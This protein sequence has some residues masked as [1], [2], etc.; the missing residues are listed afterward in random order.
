MVGVG[1]DGSPR[2]CPLFRFLCHLGHP[3]SLTRWWQGIAHGRKQVLND[4]F[5]CRTEG[6]RVPLGQRDSLSFCH[7]SLCECQASGP[8]WEQDVPLIPQ[9][10]PEWPGGQWGATPCCFRTASPP[11]RLPVSQK[12]M[13]TRGGEGSGHEAL[14]LEG[15]SHLDV[16]ILQWHRKYLAKC[17]AFFF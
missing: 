4:L 10:A 9:A 14:V 5:F 13:R 12:P 15:P 7:M 8:G 3:K 17:S 2:D 11:E 6:R 1:G 16:V